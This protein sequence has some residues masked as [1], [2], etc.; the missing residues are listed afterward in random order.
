LPRKSRIKEFIGFRLAQVARGLILRALMNQ[1]IITNLIKAKAAEL[2]FARCGIAR[3]DLLDQEAPRFQRWLDR[4]MNGEMSYMSTRIDARL[5]PRKLLEGAKSVICVAH[6]YYTN[7]RPLDSTAPKIS[8]YAQGG[9]YH[10]ILRSKVKQLLEYLHDEIGPF[11]SMISV[12]SSTVLEKAWAARAGIGWVGK[13]SLIMN[14]DV[15]S[16]MFLAVVIVDLALEYDQPVPDSCASCHVCIDVCPTGAIVEPRVVDA[17]KCIAYWTIETKS[18]LPETMKGKL[19]NWV[20]GCDICQDVCPHNRRLQTGGEPHFE[21]VDELYR[22]T[23][24][25]WHNLT[26]ETFNRLFAG[27]P[28][29]RGGLA[30]LKR[31]LDF[32]RTW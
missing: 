26:Q 21:A 25:E 17:R 12:D 20:Y 19:E 6:N 13:N 32:V 22:M 18:A 30:R 27:T 14:R 15:G 2:G 4:E 11:Q 29:A 5:D 1:P 28:L 16:F 31:N 8:K 9:D 10:R 7:K 24:A 3:A 23:A